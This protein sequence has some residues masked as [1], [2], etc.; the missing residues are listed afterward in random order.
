MLSVQCH[1]TCLPGL[2]WGNLPFHNH[3]S[4]E[5]QPI[6]QAFCSSGAQGFCGDVQ[7]APLGVPKGLVSP[8]SAWQWFWVHI[9]AT[10]V[11]RGG[12]GYTPIFR[13]GSG[14]LLFSAWKLRQ[15]DFRSISMAAT[16]WEARGSSDGLHSSEPGP[17]KQ[18]AESG[19]FRGSQ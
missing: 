12:G 6:G 9:C 7:S 11:P 19:Y 18:G 3:G 5:Q 17:G 15:R 13:G 8:V 14:T 1:I 10:K 2:S 16:D 4:C